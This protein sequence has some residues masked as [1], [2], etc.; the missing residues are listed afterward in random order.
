F[1]LKRD[2]DGLHRHRPLEHRVER[3]VDHAH[4]AAAD[5]GLDDVAAELGG[6]AAGAHPR[7]A[8]TERKIGPQTGCPAS[9]GDSS[10]AGST[11]RALR[12]SSRQARSRAEAQWMKAR[13]LCAFA[14]SRSERPRS[15]AACRL[16]AA[17]A[18]SP[19]SYWRSPVARV[20]APL[21]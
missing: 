11:A 18:Y 1:A 21:L 7:L 9:A 15:I 4:G 8:L 14:R 2:I 6:L 19:S 16:R 13:C 17:L 5:L 3:L 10:S 20:P 12:N